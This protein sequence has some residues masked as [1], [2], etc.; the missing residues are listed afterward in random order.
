MGQCQEA[1][2]IGIQNLA[3]LPQD[4]REIRLID[5]VIKTS[6]YGTLRVQMKGPE[7]RLNFPPLHSDVFLLGGQE[8]ETAEFLGVRQTSPIPNFPK[9]FI[10]KFCPNKK[11]PKETQ[12]LTPNT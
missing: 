2:L 10:P 6:V 3:P 12:A 7:N 9:Y 4:V 1:A 8:P 5:W 11:I